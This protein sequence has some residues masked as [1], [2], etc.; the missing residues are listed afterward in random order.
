MAPP[1]LPA[2]FVDAHRR[3]LDGI[4]YDPDRFALAARDFPVVWRLDGARYAQV[5]EATGLPAAIV[6]AIHWR[7]SAANF[8]TYLHNG[9]RLGQRTTIVPKGVLHHEWEP[10]AVD[11]IESHWVWAEAAGIPADRCDRALW[12]AFC[13]R[14][15]GLGYWCRDKPSPYVYSGTSVYVGGKFVADHKY[16][17]LAVDSQPGCM[18]LWHLLE[19]EQALP[20]YRR[21][22]RGPGIASLQRQL[23]VTDDG[24]F[25]PATEAMVKAWQKA[26][27]LKPDGIFGPAS[28][29]ALLGSRCV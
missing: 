23:D 20:T 12:A 29:G 27:L 21:G 16:D 10:A 3:H 22:M 2:G 6:A 4:S 1:S 7:E 28:W 8:G 18:L 5:E 15:N 19:G 26:A 13:E 25:G 9:Q 11:A 17:A 24:D 14:Y